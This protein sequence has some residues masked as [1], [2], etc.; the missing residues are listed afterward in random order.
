[1]PHE[2]AYGAPAFW[3]SNLRDAEK[4]ETGQVAN[5]PLWPIPLKKSGRGKTQ[6][7]LAVGGENSSSRLREASSA[8]GQ[9]HPQK[10]EISTSA[11]T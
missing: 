9:R 4:V 8:T 6:A 5:A 10:D 7:V 2:L 1:M 11:P 3:Q